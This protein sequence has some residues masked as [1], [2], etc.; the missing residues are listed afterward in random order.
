MDADSWEKRE[1]R[2]K[3]KFNAGKKYIP[4]LFKGFAIPDE[5]EQLAIF[6]F[7]SNK[8][9]KAIGGGKVV[10]FSEIIGEIFSELQNRKIANAAA[11]EHMPLLR[12][13]QFV[14]EYKEIVKKVWQ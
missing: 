9:H 5:V 10:L 8:N 7:G 12:S 13:F 6:V 2:Y 4:Q 14:N 1:K 3:Q 11:S